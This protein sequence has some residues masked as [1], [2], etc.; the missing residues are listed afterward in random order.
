MSITEAIRK[1]KS[2]PEGTLHN[3]FVT[4]IIVAVAISS[5]TLGRFS[6][7][8]SKNSEVEIVYPQEIVDRAEKSLAENQVVV[9]SSRGTKYHY[10]WCS[11][12]VSMSEANKIE[13]SSIEAARQA[14]YTPASNCDGLK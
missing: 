9:A 3:I 12:A 5:F 10:P 7:T 14:G 4:L 6:I 11:G 1:I 2:L 8:S 13:F